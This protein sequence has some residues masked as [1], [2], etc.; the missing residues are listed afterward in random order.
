MISRILAIL[1]LLSMA[2][3]ASAQTD[4]DEAAAQPEFVPILGEA[5]TDD[6]RQA[7][8]RN[9][10]LPSTR[11][12]TL[13]SCSLER[14]AAYALSLML[15]AARADG[16]SL[17]MEDCY[18]SYGAQAKAYERRCPLEEEEIYERDPETGENVLVGVKRSRSCSG[19]PIAM[20]GRS[21]HGWGRAIDFSTGRRVLGCQ[22][23]AF[24]WLQENGGR[25]GW[26][27]PEWAE[28]GRPSREPW[29]WEWGGLT[30]LMPVSPALART[31]VSGLTKLK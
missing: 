23:A 7:G 29:H 22:D 28:C 6:L 2:S 16:I 17:A 10:D 14:D 20:A 13:G 26:V 25:F 11:M 18:R 8:Y 15:D 24:L 12:M 4:T 30:E 27:H 5:Y 3:V 31:Y 21:N 9:G 1:M 19:P